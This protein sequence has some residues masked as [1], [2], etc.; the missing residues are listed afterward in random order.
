MKGY[1]I[2]K[3]DVTNPEG[4]KNYTALTPDVIAKFDGK[5]LVR[6]G[7]HKVV[8][9]ESRTRNTVIEFPSYQKAMECW[10]SQDYQE[11]KKQRLGHANFDIVIIQ[12]Q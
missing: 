9:G 8:E 7:E 10:E 11:A 5:F 1:W 2:V 4:F 12:G 6:A 3:G